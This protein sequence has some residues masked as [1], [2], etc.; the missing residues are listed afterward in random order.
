MIVSEY[1][2]C[3]PVAI[4]HILEGWTVSCSIDVRFIEYMADCRF[5]LYRCDY[6]LLGP[7]VVDDIARL[8]ASCVKFVKEGLSFDRSCQ[9]KEAIHIV[10]W[11]VSRKVSLKD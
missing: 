8:W 2:K 1:I 11:I 7:L 6:T 4:G 10:V 3:V 9:R 5:G